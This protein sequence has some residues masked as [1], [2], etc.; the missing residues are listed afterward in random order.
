MSQE[1]YNGNWL[2]LFLLSG[3]CAIFASGKA[4]KLRE[5]LYILQVPIEFTFRSPRYNSETPIL[6]FSRHLMPKIIIKI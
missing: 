6:I 4:S 5:K 2:C 1:E 3:F